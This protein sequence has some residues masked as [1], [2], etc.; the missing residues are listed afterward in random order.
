MRLQ[1]PPRK[2]ARIEIVPMIDAIFFLLVFF[3]YSSLSMIR[4]NGLP[5]ALPQAPDA[6]NR[7][8]RPGIAKEA[9]HLM[10]ILHEGGDCT[11]GGSPVASSAVADTVRARLQDKPET[12]VVLQAEKGSGIQGLVNIMDSLN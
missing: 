3:M 7:V 5:M 10:V 8:N 12:M 1:Q 2:R 4:L 6:T 9:P 11:V